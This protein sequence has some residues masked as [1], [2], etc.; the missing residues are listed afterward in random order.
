VSK[1]CFRKRTR[2]KK[3]NET[4]CDSLKTP[5][6]SGQALSKD[7]IQGSRRNEM[8]PTIPEI[9]NLLLRTK[10]LILRITSRF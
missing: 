4:R 3:G 5:E 2:S 10:H 1:A 9:K 7:A 6:Y 8:K